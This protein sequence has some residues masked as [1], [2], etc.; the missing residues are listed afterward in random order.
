MLSM[1]GRVSNICLS[2]VRLQLP[3]QPPLKDFFRAPTLS[4]L[5]FFCCLNTALA[6][7]LSTGAFQQQAEAIDKIRF[8]DPLRA[9]SLYK[10]LIANSEGQSDQAIGEI[11]GKLAVTY[12]VMNQMDSGIV[13]IRKALSLL[14]DGSDKALN[15]KNLGNMYLYTTDYRR[16]D[17][18]Y[19]EA[20]K[21]NR[22]KGDSLT[23]A[24][25]LGEQANVYSFQYDF[26]NCIKLLLQ[27]IDIHRKYAKEDTINGDFLRQKLADTYVM[28]KNYDFAVN[29]YLE[30]LPRMLSQKNDYRYAKTL[31]SLALVYL[32]QKNTKS[33][34][35]SL[36]LAIAVFERMQNKELLGKSYS[37]MAKSALQRGENARGLTLA[38]KGFN[39]LEHTSSP[40]LAEAATT[41]LLLLNRSGNIARGM[42]I[43]QRR[44]LQEKIAESSLTELL[45]YKRAALPFFMA[46]G[47]KEKIIREQEEIMQLI[48]SVE[49][50]ND[51]RT[52]LELQAKYQIQIKDQQQQLLEQKNQLLEQENSLHTK[53]YYLLIA[54]LFAAVGVTLYAMGRHRIKQQELRHQIRFQEENNLRLTEKAGFVERD[55]Q[56][57]E[58]IIQQQREELINIGNEMNRLQTFEEKVLNQLEM[59]SKKEMA[60]QLKLLKTDRKHLEHFMVKFN[61]IFPGFTQHLLSLYPTLTNADLLFCALVRMN[62][63]YK[64]ISSIL[65]MELM[66]V[67]KKK[68]RIAEKMQLPDNDEFEQTILN[69]RM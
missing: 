59:E 50:E 56:L 53:N 21:M 16:A 67:Y 63:S 46:T 38:E 10:K 24:I 42:E 22:L 27:A 64:E 9:N 2:Q 6:G 39:L 25:I 26:E 14:P 17:S 48:D 18:A 15:L 45:D 40:Y 31:Q 58:Q 19:A 66:S 37:L 12:A 30:L 51:R 36:S 44:E 29:T 61:T 60:E 3:Y 62:L 4:F 1:Q 32:E 54:L 55:K 69:T 34:D 52:V 41:Y 43:V 33:A 47:N 7:S 8:S 57:K 20:L 35:S 68:Y 65:S 13:V 49:N 28:T 5:L 11:L 23:T